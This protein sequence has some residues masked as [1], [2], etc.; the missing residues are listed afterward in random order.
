M[1]YSLEDA[2]KKVADNNKK[3]MLNFYIEG[4]EESKKF[5]NEVFPDETV[6]QKMEKYFC[7]VQI[8]ANSTDSLTFNGLPSTEKDIAEMLGVTSYPTTIFLD[9][10]GE[11]IIISSGYM[12]AKIFAMVLSYIGSDAYLTTEYDQYVNQQ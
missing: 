4:N 11:K 2:Q 12:K 1:W 9:N 10:S 3:V 8:D 7:S 6:T 5:H